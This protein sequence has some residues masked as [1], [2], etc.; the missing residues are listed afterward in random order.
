[1]ES[2]NEKKLSKI[3][4]NADACVENQVEYL[5]PDYLS[6]MRKL[7][8]SSA[9][10]RR[11]ASFLTEGGEEHSGIVVY[12]AVYLDNESNMHSAT[13]TGDFDLLLKQSDEGAILLTDMRTENPSVRMT[14]PRKLMAKCTVKASS[15]TAKEEV[16]S[17][18]ID[19][20]ED[21][22]VATRVANFA[23][24]IK[25]EEMEREYAE[26]LTSLLGATLD[27]IEVVYYSAEVSSLRATPQGGAVDVEGTVRIDVVIKNGDGVV[28][29]SGKD[30]DFAES[31]GCDL[32]DAKLTV[33][34]ECGVTSLVVNTA[35]TDEGVDIV[36]SMILSLGA[37]IGYNSTEDVITDGYYKG[38]QTDARYKEISYTE[39]SGHALVSESFSDEADLTEIECPAVRDVIFITGVPRLEC[40]VKDGAIHYEGEIKFSGIVSEMRED[41]EIGYTSVRFA[42]PIDR[43]GKKRDICDGARIECALTVKNVSA[44]L[45]HGKLCLSYTLE[46]ALTVM[47]DCTLSILSR[48]TAGDAAVADGKTRISVYYPE[49]GDEL[50]DIAKKFRTTEAKLAEDNSLV[51][52]TAS[53]GDT[54]LHGVK[55]LLV[56]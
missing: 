42:L 45:D 12:N 50:F 32:P 54:V 35:P 40:K 46:N 20:P 4:L 5:L 23:T 11:A 25:C 7:I 18:E 51:L 34:P 33:L 19:K 27:E 30:I 10:L 24:F 44:Y 38:Y 22:E 26:P 13:F 43:E 52:E 1:M 37:S 2:T 31:L 8:Y 15:I 17:L 36:A 56:L 55:K 14:G 21:A 3:T 48:L 49:E 29:L 9:E 53:V 6:D 39:L 41:G 28:Y 47:K 16:V